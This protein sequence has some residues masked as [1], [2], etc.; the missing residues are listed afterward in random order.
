MW[1]S[2]FI[3]TP[4]ISYGTQ[5]SQK[6]KK[7]LRVK[8]AQ[9][10]GQAWI[11]EGSGDEPVNFLDP[12]VASRVLG[13]CPVIKSHRHI[14]SFGLLGTQLCHGISYAARFVLNLQSKR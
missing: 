2:S 4:A 3:L 12:N 13:K 6:Y 9:R 14:G 11:K 1:R 7:G 5:R 8:R 10:A